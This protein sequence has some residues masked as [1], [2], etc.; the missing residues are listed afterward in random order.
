M[1]EVKAV[2]VPVKAFHD[3]KLRLA[4]VL[5]QPERDRLARALASRVI[6]AASPLPVSVVCDDHDVA[7]F[8][9]AL[10]AGVI[11]TPGRGLSG[12][13]EEGVSRLGES[14]ARMVVVAHADLPAA[15]GFGHI[16]DVDSRPDTITI[17]PDRRRDGTN[18][19][20]VPV[21]VGFRFSYGPGSFGRHVAEARRLG[22]PLEVLEDD[23]L[24]ADVDWPTDLELI[25][26]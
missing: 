11:W 16:G 15:K 14:G 7:A 17:V 9:E 5:P 19:I 10:G 2:L 25:T 8:A 1:A 23:D 12:A 24:A 21:G 13:V 4:P 26:R 18:V 3:S 22:L 20:A 6:L